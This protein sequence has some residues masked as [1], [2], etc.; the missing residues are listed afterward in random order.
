MTAE[1]LHLRV[2]IDRDLATQVTLAAIAHGT[3]V[4]DEVSAALT[5]WL[6]PVSAEPEPLA[7]ILQFES[8]GA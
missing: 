3:S 5:E 6:R 1:H 4:A 8:R 7:T 2:D